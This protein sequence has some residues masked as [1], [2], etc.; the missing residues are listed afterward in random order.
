MP[1]DRMQSQFWLGSY[2]MSWAASYKHYSIVM[3][4]VIKWD[5]PNHC[6]FPIA[7]TMIIWDAS[8]DVT[9]HYMLVVVGVGPDAMQPTGI[10][11]W[12]MP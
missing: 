4:Q 5:S 8:D 9:C 2:H 3:A 7:M 6:F 11:H 10:C 1:A 12:H